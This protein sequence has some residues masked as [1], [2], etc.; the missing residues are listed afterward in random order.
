MMIRL[1]L[2]LT[3]L[4]WIPWVLPLLAHIG[5]RKVI[6]LPIHF[7]WLL[8]LLWIVPFPLTLILSKCGCPNLHPVTWPL[9]PLC[10]VGRNG[11]LLS[12]QFAMIRRNRF[13]MFYVAPIH[14]GLQC[15]PLRCLLFYNG[16]FRLIRPQLL[17]I[18]FALLYLC[19]ALPL[20]PPMQSFLVSQQRLLKI[21]LVFLV[22]WLVV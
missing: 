6:L 18:A 1:F 17:L 4:F 9:V 14:I 8:G 12:A 16:W 21:E 20:S 3:T 22:S 19:E 5:L 13:C 2:I 10:Y 11:I 15:G 7:L